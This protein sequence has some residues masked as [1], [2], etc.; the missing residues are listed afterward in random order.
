[1][2]LYSV[3]ILPVQK[4]LLDHSVLHSLQK[5]R[6][7]GASLTSS[8]KLFHKAEA[9][10]EKACG[11]AVVDFADWYLQKAQLTGAMLSWKS[12]GRV[13]SRK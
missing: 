10:M 13:Q 12:I 5:T 11:R 4:T 6:R 7:V 3:T 2:D 9:T 8:G 1:M